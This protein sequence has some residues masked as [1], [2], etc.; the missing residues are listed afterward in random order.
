M[1]VSVCGRPSTA[2][3]AGSWPSARNAS[4]IASTSV[5]FLRRRFFFGSA[6][7]M[8]APGYSSYPSLLLKRIVTFML[9]GG[10]GGGC[11]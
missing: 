11:R 6:A 1:R 5:F 4:E 8:F 9:C 10:A 7:S 3:T 2:S